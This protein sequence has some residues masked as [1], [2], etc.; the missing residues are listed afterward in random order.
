MR[1]SAACE[2]IE[3]RE[4]ESS[5][6]GRRRRLVRQLDGD[7][8]MVCVVLGFLFL[9]EYKGLLFLNVTPVADVEG[10]SQQAGNNGD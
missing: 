9:L 3:K 6:V 5:S 4:K 8:M 2:R 1:F 10:K 7:D